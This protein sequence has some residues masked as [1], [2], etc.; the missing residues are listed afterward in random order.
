MPIYRI[1]TRPRPGQ[2]QG[3]VEQV[4]IT[5]API[6]P[7][8]EDGVQERGDV[9]ED[10]ERQLIRYTSLKAPNE[11][12]ARLLVEARSMAQAVSDSAQLPDGQTVP[13]YVIVDLVE[14]S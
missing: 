10:V 6:G 13:P 14:Q 7:P 8:D 1:E 3:W 5:D 4:T 9:V 11:A 12:E 2:Q